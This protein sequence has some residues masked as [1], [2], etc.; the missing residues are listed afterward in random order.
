ME[1][2][3]KPGKY[4]PKA[5]VAKAMSH[6]LTEWQVQSAILIVP[7]PIP[8]RDDLPERQ[9]LSLEIFEEKQF[10]TTPVAHRLNQQM[11]KLSPEARAYFLRDNSARIDRIP[12]MYTTDPNAVYYNFK[13]G[14]VIAIILYDPYT[15]GP[16]YRL[17]YRVVV[18]PPITKK[19]SAAPV[20]K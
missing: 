17:T 12:R 19:S 7:K 15:G 10:Y 16:S 20:R 13:E 8:G 9:R 18:P 5:A 1:T 14:D 4:V 2:D 11:A 6:V 3:G